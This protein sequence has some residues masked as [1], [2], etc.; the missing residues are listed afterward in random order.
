MT[1][2]TD[3]RKD[4]A[5]RDTDPDLF[6]P[7]GTAGASLR[8]IEEAKRICR[9]CPAHVQC[10]AWALDT[11]VA[12]GVW[13]GTTPDE[14]RMIRSLLTRKKTRKEHNDDKN[15]HPA[16]REEHSVRAPA[17]QPKAARILRRAGAG[18]GAGGTGTMVASD[19][20]RNQR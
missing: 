7:I 17:A 3:W 18:R 12:D 11:G 10:L 1:V 5:C 14:R 8:Q 20:A 15:P 6:F 4:A 16:E 9:I 19:A 2:R 13:A